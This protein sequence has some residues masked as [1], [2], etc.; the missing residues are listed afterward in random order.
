MSTTVVVLFRFQGVWA[1]ECTS[2]AHDSIARVIVS[3]AVTVGLQICC[4]SCRLF[5]RTYFLG[6][7]L[8]VCDR[9][10]CGIMAALEYTMQLNNWSMSEWGLGY[11]VLD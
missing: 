10:S 1:K 7:L 11:V 6:G 3:K 9:M 4:L 8:T 2:S 5:I